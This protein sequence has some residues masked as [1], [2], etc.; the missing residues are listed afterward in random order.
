MSNTFASFSELDL[1]TVTE[2]KGVSILQPGT[3]DVRVANA[4][5]QEMNNGNGHQVMV[6]LEDVGGGGSIRHWINVHH[7]TSKQAQEIGQRQLK[8]LLHH[9]QSLSQ[10]LIRLHN[11]LPN[12]IQLLSRVQSQI[13]YQNQNPHQN[14]HLHWVLIQLQ[15]LNRCQQLKKHPIN[16][17]KKISSRNLRKKILRLPHAMHPS[18]QLKTPSNQQAKIRLLNPCKNRT[19]QNQLHKILKKH[20]KIHSVV[21]MIHSHLFHPNLCVAGLTQVGTMRLLVN[22]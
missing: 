9:S 11:L 22:L 12:L 1:S 6:E 15:Q 4:E 7:K 19:R 13:R 8:S 14:P 2:A 16:Q 18:N 5:W 21:Q 17:K 10:L 20:S 3:Y